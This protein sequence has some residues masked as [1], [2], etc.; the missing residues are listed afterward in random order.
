MYINFFRAS[1]G[2]TYLGDDAQLF[3]DAESAAEDIYLQETYARPRG[4][5]EYLFTLEKQ[6]DGEWVEINLYK[7]AY[8]NQPREKSRFDE[9]E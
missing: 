3:R 4:S 1:D 6:H 5:I 7:D 9:W 2:K 8:A